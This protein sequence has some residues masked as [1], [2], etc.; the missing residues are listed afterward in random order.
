[1]KV[2]F[3][4]REYPPDTA[5][6]G[7]ASFY[8]SLSRALAQKGHEVHVICQAVTEPRE[9]EDGGVF[10]HRVGTNPKR[11]SA[12][13]RINYSFH[14]WVKLREL[15]RKRNIEI[16]EATHWGDEA[17]LYSLRKSTPLVVRFDTSASDILKT[18]TYSGLRELLNLKILS[19]LEHFSVKRAERV[20][21]ISK[22]LYALAIEKLHL[23][24]EKLDLVHHGID[25]NKY[26][27]V[28]SDVRKR[29]GIAQEYSIV[30]FAGRLEAIKGVYILCQAIPEVIKIRSASRF[31]LVGHDTNTAPSGGS[32]KAYLDQ[33]AQNHGFSDNLISLDHVCPD[34]LVQLYSACD[35]FV[36]AS[37]QES[38]GLTVIE[39]MACG[40]PIVATPT[41][42]VPELQAYGLKGLRLIPVGDAHKL[43]GAILSFLSL[44][45]EAVRE[46]AA[47]NRELVEREFSIDTWTD[48]IIKVFEKALD[49]G[50]SNPVKAQ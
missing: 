22:N 44:N 50:N 24:P 45:D 4:S 28:S 8:Y 48:K 26:R 46:I 38:F 2:T 35:V 47:E 17:F 7:I 14:A 30:L 27:F 23:H 6:G 43:S 33:Q 39:A 10:V 34:E 11:Y 15:I 36:S 40:K 37:L 19:I 12:F 20:I 1:M 29:L 16:V 3:L 42:I 13:A 31:V 41:G 49:K 25:T 21:A 9:Y 32:V 18:K 5:W